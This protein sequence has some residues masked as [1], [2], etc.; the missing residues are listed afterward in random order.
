MGKGYMHGLSDLNTCKN[1]LIWNLEISELLPFKSPQPRVK[2]VLKFL[3]KI[4]T[5]RETVSA[6][7]CSRMLWA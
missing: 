6:L 7:Q 1:R 2:H 3:V 5:T 4:G